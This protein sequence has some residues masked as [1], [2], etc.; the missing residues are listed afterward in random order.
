MRHW[1]GGLAVLF[2]CGC[3]RAVTPGD[4]GVG[5][6]TV[7][8][9]CL[10][11]TCPELC[12]VV[13]CSQQPV[14]AKDYDQ[15]GREDDVDNCP[16]VANRSQVDADGD[17]LGDA[18]DNCVSVP[19]KDQSDGD[20]DGQGDLCDADA[21]NDGLANAQDNCP[22]A[23]NPNQ[24]D[25]NKDGL[26][27]VCDP[28]ADGD[29][30]ANKVD[31]CPLVSNPQQKSTDP[32]L[33]G[34]ACDRDL[35]KD[36]IPDSKDNCPSVFN[37]DQ[38]DTNKNGVGD[39]CDADGDGDGVSNV[40]DSC[41]KVT[42]PD[43]LDSDHDGVGDACDLHFCMVVEGDV[44]NCLD[45]TMTFKVY[46]GG[47]LM[48][49]GEPTAIRLFTNR[50]DTPVDYELYVQSGPSAGRWVTFNERGTCGGAGQ[51]YECR[52]TIGSPAGLAV[53]T[54]GTYKVQIT[55]KLKSPDPVNPNFPTTATYVLTLTAQG[56]SV[57]I[58][59]RCFPTR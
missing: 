2:L 5:D 57:C 40:R 11:D 7:A 31:N 3:S 28:D 10:S 30:V 43:Q 45:P 16:F 13:D 25:A 20:G 21:D 12:K 23:P 33:Y 48:R 15:D 18:C 58:P 1:M 46:S 36:S 17:A 37:P 32:N 9:Y 47:L 55:A 51:G 8:G 41:P 4:G 29:G 38:L 56:A 34:E 59:D 27:D 35:D 24:S 14:L 52:P 49:T 26:G 44:V 19:N 6:G 54:P 53:T 42:N 22:L 50:A 39:A